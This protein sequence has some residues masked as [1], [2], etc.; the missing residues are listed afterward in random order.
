MAAETAEELGL[1]EEA[2]RHYRTAL[3]ASER[4]PS[5][6]LLTAYADLLLRSGRSAAVIALLDDA[7]PADSLWLRL[8]LAERHAGRGAAERVTALRYRLELALRGD[9]SAHAREAAFF[10]LYLDDDA[11][12]ALSLALDNWTVQRER[13]DARLVLEAAAAANSPSAAQPVRDWLASHGGSSDVWG[14]R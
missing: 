14:G 3:A 8:A 6:Y 7:P 10:A 2:E 12:R 9:D 13:I 5:I 1:R 11:P 4:E